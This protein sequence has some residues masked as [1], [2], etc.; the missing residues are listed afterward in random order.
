MGVR[1]VLRLLKG[2]G[3]EA[4]FFVPGHTAEHFPEDVGLIKDHGHEI[5]HHGYIHE[6]PEMLGGV[7]E[8]RRA[9][10]RGLRL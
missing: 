2:H 7:E 4:T 8:K 5:A 9:V 1:R 3:I 6:P 10:T